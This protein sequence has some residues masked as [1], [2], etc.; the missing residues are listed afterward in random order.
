MNRWVARL[1]QA[2]YPCDKSEIGWQIGKAKEQ[3]KIYQQKLDTLN[4][5]VI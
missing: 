4:A 2:C 1:Y 3:L 5:K